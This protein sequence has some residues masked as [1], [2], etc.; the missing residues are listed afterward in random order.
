MGTEDLKVHA[1]DQALFERIAETLDAYDA[2]REGR[3]PNY[4]QSYAAELESWHADTIA[5]RR[6]S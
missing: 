2:S 6:A 5:A 4:L 3:V 1:K